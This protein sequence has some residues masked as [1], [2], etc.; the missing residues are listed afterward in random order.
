MLHDADFTLAP[1]GPGN[2]DLVDAGPSNGSC[3]SQS[4]PE[5]QGEG[6]STTL[7]PV[8]RRR[9]RDDASRDALDRGSRDFDQWY[10]LERCPG[11]PEG[12]SRLLRIAQRIWWAK[13]S[14]VV[15]C[16]DLEGLCRA[17]LEN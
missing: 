6:L 2:A 16:D 14:G 3:P 17:A 5:V 9:S 15:D 12:P 1:P 11:S 13:F 10:G 8:C 4:S 7:Q